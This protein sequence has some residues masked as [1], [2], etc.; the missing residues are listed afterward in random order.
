[1]GTSAGTAFQRTTETTLT[2]T[3]VGIHQADRVL[4]AYFYCLLSRIEMDEKN[5][6]VHVIGDK[7]LI[8]QKAMRLVGTTLPAESTYDFVHFSPLYSLMIQSKIR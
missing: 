2:Y 4:M 7:I 5:Y 1:M 8:L 3:N 6:S